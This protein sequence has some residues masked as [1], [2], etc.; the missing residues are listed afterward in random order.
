MTVVFGLG[1]T[2]HLRMCTN[3]ENGIQRNGQQQG[4]AVNNF[5]DQGEFEALK[6]LSGH[7]ALCCDHLFHTN[8]VMS[9]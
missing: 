9:T 3:L 4:R 2:L 7:R 5:F 8:T 6:T 1:M